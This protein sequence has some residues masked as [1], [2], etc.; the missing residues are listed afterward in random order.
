[1]SV[2]SSARFGAE[3]I[4]RGRAVTGVWPVAEV[5]AAEH[6]LMATAP[7]GTLMRRAA[8]GLATVCAG[9]LPRVY[10]GRVALLVGAGNNGGDTLYAGAVLARRGARVDAV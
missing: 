9:L 7:E 4:R 10:G 5:R 6:R 3:R 8:T 1:M 2:L